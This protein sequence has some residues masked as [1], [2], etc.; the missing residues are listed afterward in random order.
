LTPGAK[1]SIRKALVVDDDADVRTIA[2]LALSVDGTVEVIACGC[3][4]SALASA[5]EFLPDVILLDVMMPDLDGP[6]TLARIR[7]IEALAKVPI[8]F[9]TAHAMPAEIQ[10]L[11]SLDAAAVL[12]KPFEPMGLLPKVRAICQSAGRGLEPA[13]LPS[14]LTP[15]LRQRLIRD[16]AELS[17]L[18]HRWESAV[19]EDIESVVAAAVH[20]THKLHGA[21]A[22]LGAP[23]IGAAADC[24]NAS[25]RALM[26]GEREASQVLPAL[27]DLIALLESSVSRSQPE[28]SA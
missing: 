14:P 26:R 16:A 6:T 28:A 9:L 23:D 3:G 27:R 11:M 2:Q 15:T 24:M 5:A 12:A 18:A 25:L 21:A 13:A 22:I 8:I 10:Q 20:C 4:E 1:D 7:D 19:S 17:R